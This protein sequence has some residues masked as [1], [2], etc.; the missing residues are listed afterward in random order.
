ML[1]SIKRS[2]DVFIHTFYTDF[3]HIVKDPGVL[4][5][6]FGATIMYPVIYSVAYSK[7][8]VRE[9]PVAV[10]DLSETK[11]S[12]TL[13]QMLDASSQIKV[14][15]HIYNFKEAQNLFYDDIVHGIII[16]PKDFERKIFRGEQTSIKAYADATYFM[17]YKQVLS[18][19]VSA[20]TT[21]GVK[22]E[23]ARLMQKGMDMNKALAQSQPLSVETNYL[24]NPSAGYASYAMPGLLIL[25]LQQT[26]LL[27]I[28][29]L[30]GTNRERNRKY[31]FLENTLNPRSAIPILLGKVS[32]FFL[33]H[34]LN[35]FF[36]LVIIYKIFGFPQK[37]NPIDIIILIIPYLLSVGFLGVAIA[38]MIKKREH[39]L[40]FMFF[41]SIPF[42]FLSGMSWPINEMPTVLQYFTKI[43][44]S[45]A[46]IQGFLRLNTMGASLKQVSHEF[47]ML[48]SLMVFY[49]TIAYLI[50]RYRIKQNNKELE[51]Q[52]IDNESKDSN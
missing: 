10:V 47:V 44:P 41:T 30:G 49:F 19:A 36:A 9:I 43:I 5:I 18:A 25:I 20:G 34:I 22:I 35:V 40:V 1:K 32:A 7:E 12:R 6:L 13:T 15:Y 37:G 45:T 23:V 28:G 24:F 31:Y 4:I 14:D 50:L 3:K 48:L 33:L 39:S 21:M 38:S 42:V 11:S 26:L 52:E 46:A 8:V 17:I 2:L 16:I 27:S 51:L 29:M